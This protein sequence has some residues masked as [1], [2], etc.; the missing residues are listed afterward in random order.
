MHHHNEKIN[1]CFVDIQ[2]AFDSFWHNGHLFKQQQIYLG[3]IYNLY[4]TLAA[5]MGSSFLSAK[6]VSTQ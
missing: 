2:K 3:A 5:C 1:A 6:I 4:V